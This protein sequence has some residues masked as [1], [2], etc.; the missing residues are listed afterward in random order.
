MFFLLIILCIIFFIIYIKNIVNIF[1][2]EVS[3]CRVLIALVNISLSSTFLGIALIY[4]L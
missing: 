1:K 2:N 4:F 3:I